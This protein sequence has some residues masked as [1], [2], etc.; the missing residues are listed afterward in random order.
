MTFISY[1]IWTTRCWHRYFKRLNRNGSVDTARGDVDFLKEH[2]GDG[3]KP[4]KRFTDSKYDGLDGCEDRGRFLVFMMC[5]YGTRES[6]SFE[7]L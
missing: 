7:K 3:S 5:R 6:K 1:S 4:L 2:M